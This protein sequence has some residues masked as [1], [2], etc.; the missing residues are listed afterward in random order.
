MKNGWNT[1][2]VVAVGSSLKFYINNILVWTGSDSS[3]RT[4][5]VGFG[6]Y[7][8]GTAGTLFVDS[9]SLSTTATADVNPFAD[10]L[11]G[12]ELVGGSIDQSPVLP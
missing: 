5:T 11:A 9:A 7:R 10:V 4:G 6:F 2:K 1:L 8:D 3:L 12:E